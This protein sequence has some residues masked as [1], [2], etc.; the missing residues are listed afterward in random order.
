M[1]I[2]EDFQIH[3]TLNPKLWDDA[4]RLKPEVKKKIVEIVNYFEE[5]LQIPLAIA[6]IQLCGSN[7]SYNYTEQSDL[8][9]HIVAN[10]EAISDETE[11]LQTVYDLSKTKFNSSYDISIHGVEI[12]LYVQDI[13]SG[14]NSNGIYSVLDNN[15]IKEPKPINHITKH[16][17]QKELEKW[18]AHIAKVIKVGDYDQILN[19]IN[20]LYLIRH[21]SLNTDGEYGKGN[22]LFKDIR[23]LGLLDK[24]KGALKDATSKRLSLESYTSGQLVNRI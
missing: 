19:A 12:E 24:L 10:F 18:Q 16:N 5:N 22:A 7:A 21:N 14:V 8:D 6:D 17:T 20:T 3:D 23:N 1:N 2:N 11:I 4:K 13:Q 15:W 9:V